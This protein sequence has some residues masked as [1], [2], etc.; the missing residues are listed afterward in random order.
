MNGQEMSGTVVGEVKLTE[1]ID[2]QSK[3]HGVLLR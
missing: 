1:S 3:A 2:R